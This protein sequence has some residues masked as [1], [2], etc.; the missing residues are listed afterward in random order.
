MSQV[1]S[2][3][4]RRLLVA[5]R[6]G[7]ELSRRFQRRFGRHIGQRRS[8]SIKQQKSPHTKKVE[9]PMSTKKKK[10]KRRAF[11]RVQASVITTDLRVEVLVAIVLAPWRVA[12]R[13]LRPRVECGDVVQSARQAHRYHRADR[14]MQGRAES[15]LCCATRSID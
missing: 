5:L 9:K 4:R 11:C 13:S 14:A 10:N 8:W 2:F 7:F 6:F 3:V 1:A 12:K 15:C